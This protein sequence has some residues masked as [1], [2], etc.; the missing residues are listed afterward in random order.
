MEDPTV[1]AKSI[2]AGGE[3]A[4]VESASKDQ[5]S[6]DT[7]KSERFDPECNLVLNIQDAENCF[8]S[9]NRTP[10]H[11]GERHREPDETPS[12]HSTD[13]E[14]PCSEASPCGGQHEM[15]SSDPS[16]D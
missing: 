9:R 6:S 2:R 11:P 16:S 14:T 12:A 10:E 8:T 3:Y 13:R 4:A 5:H 15:I 1:G 7:R